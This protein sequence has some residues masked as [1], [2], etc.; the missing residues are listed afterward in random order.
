MAKKEY[1]FAHAKEQLF[2]N[3]GH[4]PL[5][6]PLSDY[7]GTFSHPGYLSLT[8]AVKNGSLII[9]ANDRTWPF[10]VEFEHISG[11]H[12]LVNYFVKG[13]ENSRV[14]TKVEFQIRADGTVIRMGCLFDGPDMAWFERVN[15]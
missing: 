5:S 2:P 13:D 11:E 9:D 3:P 14:S 7:E 6:L 15:K 1:A 12:F 10:V 8:V 4:L